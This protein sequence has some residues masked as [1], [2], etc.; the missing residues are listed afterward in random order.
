MFGI[1]VLIGLNVKRFFLGGCQEDGFF[2]RL[3]SS[4]FGKKKNRSF[5]PRT[6]AQSWVMFASAEVGALGTS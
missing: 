4:F 6:S 5:W 2:C 1:E 3:V